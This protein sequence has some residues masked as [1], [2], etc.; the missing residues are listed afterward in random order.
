MVNTPKGESSGAIF[1]VRRQCCVSSAAWICC[2]KNT[3][4]NATHIETCTAF[5]NPWVSEVGCKRCTWESEE[6]T[7]LLATD[8][9]AG[10]NAM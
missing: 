9:Q 5:L 10:S 6:L 3:L 2:V 8:R 4:P 1:V 7:T